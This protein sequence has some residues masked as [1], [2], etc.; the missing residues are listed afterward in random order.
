MNGREGEREEVGRDRWMDGR[1]GVCYFK[2]NGY[3]TARLGEE[4]RC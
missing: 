2:D 3:T 1:N 4:G